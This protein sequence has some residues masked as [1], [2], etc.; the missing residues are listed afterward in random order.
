MTMGMNVASRIAL[1]ALSAYAGA[2]SPRPVVCNT[3]AYFSEVTRGCVGL[4]RYREENDGALP[5]GYTATADSSQPEASTLDVAGRDASDVVTTADA[6]DGAEGGDAA[7]IT[8]P[9][10]G[11]PRAIA[12]LSTS[13]V[14]SQRPT[15]RWATSAA[16]DGAVVEVSRTREFTVLAH[17]LRAIGDRVRLPSALS[18]GVWFWRLRGRDSMRNAE[19]TATS[20]VWWFRVGARSADADRDVSW[21]SELDVNGDGYTDVAVGAAGANGGLGRVDVYYGGP[22][23]LASSPGASLVGTVAGDGF[24]SSVANAGDVTGDGFADLLVAAPNSSPSGRNR[25]GTTWLFAG[26]AGGLTTTPMTAIDGEILTAMSGRWL[27]TAGDVNAD[28]FADIIVGANGHARVFRGSERG[29][30]ASVEQV[31]W[32]ATSVAGGADFNADGYG[33]V[34]VGNPSTSAGGRA[35]AGTVSIF[36]GGPS[37][38]AMPASRVLEGSDVGDYFGVHVAVAGDVDGDGFSDLIVGA[39]GGGT[40][41]VGAASVFHGS[42]RGIVATPARTIEGVGPDDVEFGSKVSGVGDVNGDGYSDVAV[43]CHMCAPSGRTTVGRV[44][45]HHGSPTGVRAS[46]ARPLSG[47]AD[48][49]MFG[50]SVASAGDVNGDGFGELIVG[51]PNAR[52]WTGAAI[53][54]AGSAEGTAAVAIRTL[55]GT[56]GVIG[57]IG[58]HVGTSVV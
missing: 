45:V 25:A 24:A 46:A 44:V 29:A 30:V 7:T 13:T 14:T 20:P 19:G 55:V 10:L 48:G 22:T 27:S 15:L 11:A 57:V 50:W 5:D 49:D 18:A 12:P 4:D 3:G 34:A 33:D 23:G 39:E 47:D 54:F 37:G 56:V 31:I 38:L 1:L 6:S 17:S 28:G 8:D 36:S 40:M 21:G 16:I 2:C 9:M 52:G 41:N 58:D 53:L 43:A 26:A 32:G 35:G 42:D 51:A